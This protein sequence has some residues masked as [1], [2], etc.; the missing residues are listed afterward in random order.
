ML[1]Y[2][3]GQGCKWDGW[4][5]SYAADEI[6]KWSVAKLTQFLVLVQLLEAIWISPFGLENEAVMGTLNMP[7][8]CK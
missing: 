2:V 1:K 5:M 6:V 3:L 4:T 8:R 7:K